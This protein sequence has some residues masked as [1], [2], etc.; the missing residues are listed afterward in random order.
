MA[1]QHHVHP[2]RSIEFPVGGDVIRL[3]N[4]IIKSYLPNL[5]RHQGRRART[6]GYLKLESL[7]VGKGKNARIALSIILRA[8]K[9]SETQHGVASELKHQL[10]AARDNYTL[11][12]HD[13]ERAMCSIFCNVARL[14]RPQSALGRHQEMAYAMSSWFTVLA[15]ED[16]LHPSTMFG[17]IQA[18][19]L[20][21]AD[22]TGPLLSFLRHT[23]ISQADLRELTAERLLRPRTLKKFKAMWKDHQKKL[24]S[25]RQL[26]VSL[27]DDVL[28]GRDFDW[29]Q[30]K[31]Q[32][33]ND[34][35]SI[36]IDLRPAQHRDFHDY[37]YYDGYTTLSD[38]D[39]DDQPYVYGH[40]R[41]DQFLDGL[42]PANISWGGIPRQ[43][44]WNRQLPSAPFPSPGS[45]LL[46][47][48]TQF[49][50]RP[51]MV[52]ANTIR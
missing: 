36:I 19:D 48:R 28:T 16:M 14:L 4:E 51:P 5:W 22:L 37:D 34:P 32:Y 20:L 23:R 42:P 6:R 12:Q 29:K 27:E 44:P 52:R 15:A 25:E 33:D 2:H 47:P 11:N 21:H 39:Y 26:D 38:T 40:P 41:F 3:P 7:V 46:G 10:D 31:Q 30:L 17:Y 43:H 13:P 9:A 45:M 24:R 50:A 18:L 49:A 35:D 1:L 8:L